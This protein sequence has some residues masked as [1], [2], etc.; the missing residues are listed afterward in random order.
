MATSRKSRDC[1]HRVP[2]SLMPRMIKSSAKGK[3]VDKVS[4]LVLFVIVL[5]IHLTTSGVSLICHRWSGSINV[6][7]CAALEL[8]RSEKM[9]V[10][11]EHLDGLLHCN[12][13]VLH[14]QLRL[15]SKRWRASNGS[16][17]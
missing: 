2:L 15:C 14:S 9:F 7:N 12:G 3:C 1:L 8:R 13:S 6:N 16:R 5:T 17:R 4:P 11:S 10:W